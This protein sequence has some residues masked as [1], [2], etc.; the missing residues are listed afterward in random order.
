[1]TTGK[2]KDRERNIITSLDLNPVK[3]EIINRKLQ[4]KFKKIEET[5]VRF[6]RILCDDAEYLFVAYGSSARV[7]Q[8][9]VQLG[10]AKG[11]KVGLLRPI[12]LFPFPTK[13]VAKLAKQVKGIQCIEMSAG[14]MVE[15]VRLAV[16]GAVGVE[17][18][19]RLGGI[20]PAPDEVLNVL[21]QNFVKA[22]TY[23]HTHM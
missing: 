23:E 9:A 21:E 8:K 10:R 4:E 19:G 22:K 6:E 2:T 20:I 12:T 3:Q 13:E 18:Y 11:M 15:D 14:Q 7:C 1:A 16:N 5:E 17:H